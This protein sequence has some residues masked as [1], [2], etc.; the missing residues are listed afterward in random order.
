MLV[1]HY[2]SP[3]PMDPSDGCWREIGGNLLLF[4]EYFSSDY[5][6]RELI[7]EF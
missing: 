6:V 2:G 3:F 7:E 5:R 1:I 4:T